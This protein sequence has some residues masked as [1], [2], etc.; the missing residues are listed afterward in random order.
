MWNIY[1]SALICL[2]RA[3]FEIAWESLIMQSAYSNPTQSGGTHMLLVMPRYTANWGGLCEDQKQ[4]M[5]KASVTM[6]G[7]CASSGVNA[8]VYLPDEIE[9]VAQPMFKIFHRQ[10]HQIFILGDYQVYVPWALGTGDQ[11]QPQYLIQTSPFACMLLR[12]RSL[13]GEIMHNYFTVHPI[14]LISDR[15]SVNI[16]KGKH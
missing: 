14:A 10:V 2:I 8:H 13:Q 1:N 15:N 12:L 3:S 4:H 11:L 9:G 7:I 16:W 5:R 6:N